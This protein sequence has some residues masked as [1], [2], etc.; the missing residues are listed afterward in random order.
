MRTLHGLPALLVTLKPP[1]EVLM[2][3]VAQRQMT[4]KLPVEV[5]GGFLARYSDRVL[6]PLHARCLVLDDGAT[7]VAIA[8]RLWVLTSAIAVSGPL[9]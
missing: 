4:K 3:R 9:G 5:S 7:S 6:D 8:V 2:E 1:Y